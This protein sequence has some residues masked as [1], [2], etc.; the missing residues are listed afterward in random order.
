VVLRITITSLGQLEA[1]EVTRSSGSHLLDGAAVDAVQRA[2][3]PPFPS[4]WTIEKL[5]LHAQFNYQLVTR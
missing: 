2:R 5:H 4:H 1:V 3:I